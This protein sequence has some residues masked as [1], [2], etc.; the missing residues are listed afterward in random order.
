MRHVVIEHPDV[1]LPDAQLAQALQSLPQARRA[2]ALRYRRPIDCKCSVLAY[3]LVEQLLADEY[4]IGKI[5]P[6]GFGLYGKPF[7]KEYPTLHFNLS[8]C[9]H[10]VACV[11]ADHPVGI[12]VEGMIDYNSDLLHRICSPQETERI[13]AAPS[14]RCELTTLWTQ[15]E[16]LM[17]CDG[18]GLCNDLTTVLQHHDRYHLETHHAPDYVLSLCHPRNK[19]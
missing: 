11:V 5:G 9:P 14:P 8:H 4:G 6:W 12:D 18:I 15:K 17:K 7:L 16:A 2:V 1:A 13:L 19:R 10:A 3:R